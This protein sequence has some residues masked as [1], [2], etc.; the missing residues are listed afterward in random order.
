MHAIKRA[1]AK[2][3]A[4]LQRKHIIQMNWEEHKMILANN[5]EEKP[6]NASTRA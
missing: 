6:V 2:Q 5:S 3:Y 1:V 4:R